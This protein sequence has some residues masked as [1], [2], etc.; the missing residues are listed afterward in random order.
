VECRL[1]CVFLIEI[2]DI[3]YDYN[4]GSL[5]FSLS[6][7][8]VATVGSSPS[9]SL[10]VSWSF[11]SS[12]WS[13]CTTACSSTAPCA[14]KAF[15][16]ILTN[17]GS[18]AQTIFDQ[19]SSSL[20]SYS[21]NVVGLPGGTYTFTVDSLRTSAWNPPD[22]STQSVRVSTGTTSSSFCLP[23]AP[24]STFAITGPANAVVLSTSSLTLTWSLPSTFGISCST[25]SPNTILVFY[26]TSAT[27]TTNPNSP[28]LAAT[29]GPTA[30]SLP[31][32]GLANGRYWFSMAASNGVLTSNSS[33]LIMVDIC[34]LTT[35]VTLSTPASGALLPI[36]STAV[37]TTLSWS[38]YSFLFYCGSGPVKYTLSASQ[39]S[40]LSNNPGL[41]STTDALSNLAA[42]NWSWAVSA[43]NNNVLSPSSLAW[44]FDRC[45]LTAP[46]TPT[47]LAPTNGE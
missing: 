1:I 20:S 21:P 5:S 7:P 29:V 8:A 11:G 25:G 18:G 9:L 16:V 43:S 40:S 41:T 32:T 23:S 22:L 35:P 4:Y 26:S 24:D 37:T 39:G 28:I 27:Q 3:Y 13:T 14:G 34:V 38:A 31:L 45:L 42:G 15:R 10:T 44:T 33:S 2:G 17:T 12:Y 6:L 47:L 36:N 19:L 30:V 46:A